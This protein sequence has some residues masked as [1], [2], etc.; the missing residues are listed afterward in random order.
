MCVLFKVIYELYLVLYKYR[1]VNCI[2]SFNYRGI[3]LICLLI[4]D[5]SLVIVTWWLY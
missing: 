3:L 4:G 5:K 2:K 1:K